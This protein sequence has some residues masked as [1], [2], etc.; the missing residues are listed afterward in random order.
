[1]SFLSGPRNPEGWKNV[2]GYVAA[3]VLSAAAAAC[4]LQLWRA[5]L[6][7]PLWYDGDSLMGQVLVQD[8]LESGSVCE[9]GRLGAPGAMDMGDFPIPDVLHI[10]CL[11]TLGLF[12]HDSGLVLNLYGLLT[13]PLTG[14]SGYFVLRR[15]RVGRVAG[16]AGAVLYAC[17]PCHFFRLAG[18]HLLLADL[19]QVPLAA[20]LTLRVYA[21]RNPFRGPPRR[22]MTWDAAGAALVC[23]LTGLAG[24]YYAFFSC[25]LLLAAGAAAAVRDRR[26]ATLA[27]SAVPILFIAGSLGAALAPSVLY[28]RQH[29]R[30]YEVGA[31]CAGEADVYGLNISEML[32]PVYDHRIAY[33]SQIRER[34]EAAPRTPTGEAP[35][36]ALGALAS[37][38]FVYL[39]G[40]FLWRR[41]RGR[42][43]EDGLAFL[44]VAAVVLGTVGGLGSQIAYHVSPMIRCYNRLSVFIAFFA[45]AALV[46]LVRRLSGRFVTGWRSAAAG[47]R[48][49]V[50]LP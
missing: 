17:A 50:W 8:V 1:M 30:N 2:A 24:V 34:F 35:A 49:G 9:N 47:R 3:A 5:D 10:F 45:T 36:V 31:R 25:F 7:I 14:L 48:P 4:A 43:T 28:R 37:L 38:G 6:R 22:L 20:W 23:I 40:R 13:F 29:G 21:G 44:A 39:V 16:A 46:L 42:R 33:L 32:M 41:G 18:G 12:S 11:Q 26:W 15:L 27:A 19:Y